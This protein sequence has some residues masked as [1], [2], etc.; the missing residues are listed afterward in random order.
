[1]RRVLFRSEASRT[2]HHSSK[3][4]AKVRV[5]STA[6]SAS[7]NTRTKLIALMWAPLSAAIA[8]SERFGRWVAA[9]SERS[10][11]ESTESA[12]STAASSPPKATAMTATEM[13]SANMPGP[14]ASSFGVRETHEDVAL[15]PEHL[16]IGRAHV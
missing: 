6:A 5:T 4:S 11:R 1:F 15:Q 14:S 3:S 8:S 2:H 10:L 9:S 12:A 13:N 7:E 16:E